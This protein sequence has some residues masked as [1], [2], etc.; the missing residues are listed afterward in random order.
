MMKTTRIFVFLAAVEVSWSLPMSDEGGKTA[1][2]SAKMIIEGSNDLIELV[3]DLTESINN[4]TAAHKLN[5]AAAP[6][7]KTG[8]ATLEHI[9]ETDNETLTGDDNNGDGNVEQTTEANDEATKEPLKVKDGYKPDGYKTSD[10]D[11]DK[12]D[13][14]NHK[15]G[16]YS[17]SDVEGVSHEVDVDD[18]ALNEEDVDIRKDEIIH[19]NNYDLLDE[20]S[21]G[22]NI[23][24]TDSGDVENHNE[25]KT[26][27][28]EAYDLLSEDS[29]GSGETE[30]IDSAQ[31]NGINGI[32]S[33]PKITVV[34]EENG[35]N[36]T[37][38]NKNEMGIMLDDLSA[39]EDEYHYETIEDDLEAL[40]EEA[41][42]AD[43]DTEDINKAIDDVILGGGYTK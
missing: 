25:E 17:N 19:T 43:N 6:E 14:T 30:M 1:K 7:Q 15:T 24:E 11:G 29:E 8:N 35:E 41:E 18:V 3:E 10:Y 39:Y 22:A 9:P 26:A 28:A 42:I 40:A 12:E 4:A 34:V 36:T 20:Y 38:L 37:D 21:E 16:G 13:T 27:Y 31:S 5:A 33:D 32:D 23:N 2:E